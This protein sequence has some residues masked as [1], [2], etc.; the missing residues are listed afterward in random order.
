MTSQ[1]STMALPSDHDGIIVE[2]A[3]HL[4]FT[5]KP[6]LAL[7]F[8]VNSFFKKSHSFSEHWR[9]ELNSADT[10]VGILQNRL[11]V[12][13][14]IGA[15]FIL[16]VR[17]LFW[18]S[19]TVSIGMFCLLLAQSGV[20]IVEIFLFH[21]WAF[22]DG[23]S[24]KLP[25]GLVGCIVV[26]RHPALHRYVF[27]YIAELIFDSAMLIVTIVGLTKMRWTAL[28]SRSPLYRMLLIHCVAYFSILFAANLGNVF[29]FIM[30]DA[31]VMRSL[32]STHQ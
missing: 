2:T 3:R 30:K 5:F 23:T 18:W 29:L 8:L 31:Y 27:T 21:L 12:S 25:K 11:C 7:W 26:P 4:K 20:K 16:R 15:Y 24:L 10:L 28:N 14:V 1:N 17:A 19:R 6:T 22:T 13:I 32:R 9:K